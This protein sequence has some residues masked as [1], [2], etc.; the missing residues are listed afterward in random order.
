MEGAA[1]S[2]SM[3]FSAS[4]PSIALILLSAWTVRAQELEPRAYSISPV[5]VNI[6]VLANTF[7]SGDI[8][9]DPAV[10]IEQAKAK[11][12]ASALGYVRT[13]NIVGRSSSVGFVAPYV[14]GHLEGLYLGQFQTV[15]RSGLGDPR[16]RFAI[17][18]YGAPAMKLREFAS[19]R[20]KTNVGV[21]LVVGAPLG[22]Y[23]PAK[24]INLGANR[25]SFKPELGVSRAL[26]RWT[27]EGF[28]GVWLYTSNSK[29][30]NGKT[31]TQEPIGSL[32]FHLG[33]T[34]WPRFWAAFDA[35]FYNGGRTSINGVRSFDL[36]QN[37]RMGGTLAIP[38][39][40]HQSFK[41]SYSHGAHTTIGGNFNS[42]GISYQYLWGGGL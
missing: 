42:I 31:R 23:D 5:G 32:Q 26:G 40:R 36:Q 4:A 25:W 38:L 15:D 16:F 35:N 2:R 39:N 3:R 21:S 10:P 29:F 41:F 18:L 9:F 7:N 20:P 6:L 34:L 13:L 30:F 33:Y 19:Y 1:S 12:N 22:Q 27:A 11:I 28:A 37:S 24:A 8:D 17:N 14:L